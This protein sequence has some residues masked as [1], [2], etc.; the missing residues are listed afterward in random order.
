MAHSDNGGVFDG[1]NH[2]V[3]ENL[4]DNSD[5]I[6]GADVGL[7]EVPGNSANNI[8]HTNKSGYESIDDGADEVS[9]EGYFENEW[10]VEGYADNVG[11]DDVD[12]PIDGHPAP[13][14][15]LVLLNKK[16]SPPLC[17]RMSLY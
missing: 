13:A 17:N 1:T 7:D 3:D 15:V 6:D 5:N 11:L 4:V 16:S 12:G 9:D 2:G 10:A 8:I 14:S